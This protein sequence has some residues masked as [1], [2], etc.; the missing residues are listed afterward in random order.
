M[1]LPP[2]IYEIMEQDYPIR[3]NPLHCY[4]NPYSYLLHG[5]KKNFKR[6]K[7]LS[8]MFKYD[9]TKNLKAQ[10]FYRSLKELEMTMKLVSLKN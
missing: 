2:K 6:S 4:R 5:F 7:S 10:I 9:S 8:R 1:D 3:T